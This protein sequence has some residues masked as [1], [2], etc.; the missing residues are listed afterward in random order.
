MSTVLS[1]VKQYLL[2]K[3]VILKNIK[4][5]IIMKSQ[6][7]TR[8]AK[9]VLALFSAVSVFLGVVESAHAGFINNFSD[10]QSTVKINTNSRHVLKFTSPSGAS[11]SNSTIII[12]FPSTSGYVFTN[13]ATS[14]ITFTHGATTGLETSESFGGVQTASLWGIAFSGVASTTLTLTAPTDGVGTAAVAANDKLIITL[15]AT[16]AL[17]PV[18]A[19]SYQIGLTGSFGDVG[20]TTVAIITNDTVTINAL[21][22]QTIT[23]AISSNS[24]NFGTLGAGAAKFASSTNIAGDTAEN[25]AHTLAVATNAPSGYSITASGTTLTSQQNSAFTITEIGTIPA[26]STIATEQFGIR[27]TKAGGVNGTIAAPYAMSSSYGY[28]ATSSA[29]TFASGTSATAT[30]TY[31]LRYV[32]NITALTEAGNYATSIIYVATANF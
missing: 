3:L 28:N 19:G 24:I 2:N 1:A 14:T 17:N 9:S 21:V 8:F 5:N 29:Q 27:A 15:D 20:T 32:A 31:S 18:G 23:F 6:S 10:T 7:L 11:V 16:N 12:T 30:E 26:S 13:K 25:V 22:D 4:S